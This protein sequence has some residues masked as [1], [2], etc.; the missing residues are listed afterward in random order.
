MHEKLE[1]RLN[2]RLWMSLPLDRLAIP[3]PPCD[4]TY[5]TDCSTKKADKKKEV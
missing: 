1:K 4:C 5:S 3:E 2:P